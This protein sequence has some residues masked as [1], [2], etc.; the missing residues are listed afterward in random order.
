MLTCVQRSLLMLP[1]TITPARLP[2]TNPTIAPSD[3]GLKSGP[4][5]PEK[6][7]FDAVAVPITA[8]AVSPTIAPSANPID[9]WEC[10][11]PSLTHSPVTFAAATVIGP[12]SVSTTSVLSV[13]RAYVPTRGWS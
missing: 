10:R 7:A 11:F 4:P 9:S 3:P 8:P 13:R 5:S 2:T 1:P 12:A 6:R